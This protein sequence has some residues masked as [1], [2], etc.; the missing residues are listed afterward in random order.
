MGRVIGGRMAAAVGVIGLVGVVAVQGAG[1]APRDVFRQAGESPERV[2]LVAGDAGA[3]PDAG[4]DGRLDAPMLV[5]LAGVRVT[6]EGRAA[7]RLASLARSA[8]RAGVSAGSGEAIGTAVLV[9][10][11]GT[12]AAV[13]LSRTAGGAV[14]AMREGVDEVAVLEEE[15]FAALASGWD[16]V[17]A[18]EGLPRGE[19]VDLPGPYA[20]SDEVLDEK[21][22]RRRLAMSDT[23]LTAPALSRDLATE[24]MWVRL[25]ASGAAGEAAAGGAM[26]VVVWISPSEAWRIPD[27]FGAALDELG[28]MAIGADNAGNDR[29]IFDRLQL[30]LD[31]VA[32]A[33]RRFVVDGRRVYLA[34]FSGGG[35]CSTMLQ[36]AYPERFAGAVPIVGLNSW[37]RIPLDDGK[38]VPANSPQPGGGETALARGRRVFAISGSKDYNLE[39]MEKRVEKLAG[40]K[41]PVRLEVVPGMP[42]ERMPPAALVSEGVRWVDEPWREAMRASGEAAAQALAAHDAAF[43]A[44]DRTDAAVA[45]LNAIAREHPWTGA[46]MEIARRLGLVAAGDEGGAGGGEGG[47]EGG[48]TTAP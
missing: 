13:R 15:G 6:L 31:A 46:S 3:G 22:I 44:E 33:E 37:H 26:G 20:A 29:A 36:Y 28:L 5:R 27:E 35:R 34:G 14:L 24:R 43:A 38:F 41:Y 7:G 47:G 25:P 10:A 45:S 32:T 19:V 42:H 23:T 12:R 11:D 8:E 4:F 17:W 9:F 21:T 18:D 1:A 40:A 16:A 39:E 48:V 30:V 2:Y